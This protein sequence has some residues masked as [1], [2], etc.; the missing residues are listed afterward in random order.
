MVSHGQCLKCEFSMVGG[1]GIV[2]IFLLAQSKLVDALS[3]P[4][5]CLYSQKRSN[6]YDEEG[7]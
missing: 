2:I 3:I 1:V 5:N 6:D 4:W 7:Y